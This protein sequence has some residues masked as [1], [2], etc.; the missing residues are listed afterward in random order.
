MNYRYHHD[1]ARLKREIAN[2]LLAGTVHDGNTPPDPVPLP[3]VK[4]PKFL[5]W[6]PY[7]ILGTVGGGVIGYLLWGLFR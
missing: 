6:V 5:D 1:S 7:L 3:P 4:G 2:R